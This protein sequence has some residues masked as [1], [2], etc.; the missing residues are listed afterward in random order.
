ML[1]FLATL[2][3]LSGQE[4]EVSYSPDD[5]HLQMVW[6]SPPNPS[7]LEPMIFVDWDH[8]GV[9]YSWCPSEID[10][11]DAPWQERYDVCL[12]RIPIAFG[13]VLREFARMYT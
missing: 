7:W 9:A 2:E 13:R 3:A 12:G 8:D 5:G 11:G 6:K 1:A 4:A 10:D